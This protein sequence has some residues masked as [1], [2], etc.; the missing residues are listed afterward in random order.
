MTAGAVI[1]DLDARVMHVA[2]GPP[3]ENAFVP[4]AV[5]AED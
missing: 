1:I 2:D 3:C 5:D 4:F